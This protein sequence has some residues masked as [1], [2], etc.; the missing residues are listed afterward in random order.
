MKRYRNLALMAACLLLGLIGLSIARSGMFISRGGAGQPDAPRP[1]AAGTQTATTARGDVEDVQKVQLLRS[2]I[3]S[4][5]AV[6]DRQTVDIMREAAQTRRDEAL[7]LLIKALAFNLDPTNRNESM[8]P[9]MLLPAIQ[10]IKENYGEKAAPLLYG[11]A[12]TSTEKWYRNRIA[13]A[14]RAILQPETIR[15][16]NAKL[17]GDASGSGDFAAALRADKIDLYLA[18]PDS[19][20]L[21]NKLDKIIKDK[22]RKNG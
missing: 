20:N 14:V 16:M 22:R 9:E 11:E 1:D 15:D 19:Q 12:A 6:A 18:R 7:P 5:P 17:L 13:L 21:E 10:L 4:A 8:T 2:I 3:P